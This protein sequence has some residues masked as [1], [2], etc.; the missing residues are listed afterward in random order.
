MKKDDLFPEIS[1]SISDFLYDEEGN[2]PRG[3]ILA[4][5]S[6]MLI[7]SI[8]FVDPALAYH[9]SHSSHASHASHE[10]HSSHVSHDSHD[11]H[12]SHSSMPPPPKPTP[13]PKMP[14]VQIPPD[15]TVINN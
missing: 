14:K 1:K 12:A 9:G 5:G 2:I 10:S 11:S 7:L 4:V 6:I 15:T 3:K 8:M 13:I